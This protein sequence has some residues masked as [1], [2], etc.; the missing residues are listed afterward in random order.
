MTNSLD[1]QHWLGKARGLGKLSAMTRQNVGE[2]ELAALAEALAPRLRPGD[3]I[4]LHGEL[5]AGK[6][7]FARALIRALLANPD[8]EVPSP[9]FAL[10]QPYESARFFILHFDFYRL[11]DPAE[12]AELG[13]DDALAQGIAIAEWPER[14][15]EHLPPDRL[16]IRLGDGD[17]L[18]KRHI[19]LAGQGS[20]APRLDRFAAA[21]RFIAESGWPGA[22]QSYVN[23]DASVRSY[24]RLA[25]DGKSALLM[26]WPRQPDGPPIRGNLP[27]SRIAHLAEDVRPFVAVANALREAGL[28]APEIY[29]ADF[30]RGF[31]LIED[32]GDAVFTRLAAQGADM[33]PLYRLAVDALLVLR[34]KTPPAAMPY[35]GGAHSLP[36]YDRE[37]LGIE[38]ELLLDWF[39]PAIRGGE[40]PAAVRETFLGLWR[41][42]FDWLL[43]QPSG[44][45]Q[46]DYHSPNLNLRDGGEGLERLGIIDFQDALRGHPAYDLVSL[47]QDARID[48][49][50]AIEPELIGYY[51]AGAAAQEPG[52]DEAAFFR[53]Y[54]LLG[55]QRN[56]KI[57][58]I[59]A[60]LARRDGKR[61]YLQHMPRVARYLTADLQHLDLADLKSWYERELPGDIA[62]L[63]AR[64]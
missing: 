32:F 27:Y 49:D 6:T 35:E 16:D 57:L 7:T 9:T 10:V 14:L 28:R 15:G 59:F 63:A 45:V 53:A 58:G 22:R 37:A 23:G 29:A 36:A 52:F 55:A 18:D 50:P 54:R 19:T 39:L 64:F 8:E 17:S 20:W 60:R 56:T 30:A 1:W 46:R 38:T 21:E 24:A 12:A 31:L 33:L 26:D 34:R 62:G 25:R 13:L 48:L 43:A 61:A 5:G 3:F 4:A 47:L 11:R 42:Q 44:W 51:C 41:A 40:P 2:G